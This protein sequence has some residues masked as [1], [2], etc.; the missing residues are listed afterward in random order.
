MYVEAF[1]G[2]GI[3]LTRGAETLIH[4]SWFVGQYGKGLPFYNAAAPP[5]NVT[6]FNTTAVQ[7]NGNDHYV[8]DSVIWQ[9]T[10]RGVQ[11]NGMG[12]VIS[13]VHAWGCGSTWC[14]LDW[15]RELGLAS[16]S[17]TGIA[18]RAPRNRVLSCYL[19]GNFLDI[20]D[21]TDVVV[22]SSFFLGTSTRL[23]ATNASNGH[24]YGLTM[25][26]N[27]LDTIELVG[28]FNST[29]ARASIDDSN[30]P[31]PG[32]GFSVAKR[33]GAKLTTVRR[34]I[35]SKAPR[36]EY[37]FNLT[38]SEGGALDTLLLGSL[39]YMQY[40]VVFAMGAASSQHRAVEVGAGAVAILFDK[41]A[42]VTVH[43]E[44]R[45]CLGGH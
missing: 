24:L 28:D 30:I 34:S 2:V 19:D 3:E 36:Q 10:R 6:L 15:Y 39:D 37:V 1:Q 27:S 14:D 20:L 4:N 11:V 43:V 17:L 29:D 32:L 21:P 7:I 40:S 23:I 16:K 12:A 41:P 25:V 18:I 42:A 31:T 5:P 8:V 33:R 38:D 13:G 22:S 9:Y 26:A 45:C 35:R 44:A